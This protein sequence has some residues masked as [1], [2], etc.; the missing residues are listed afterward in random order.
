MLAQQFHNLD[1]LKVGSHVQCGVA[2]CVLDFGVGHGTEQL[3]YFCLVAVARRYVQQG[4]SLFVLRVE[5]FL[6]CD[7][8]VNLLREQ[9]VRAVP[10]LLPL[11]VVIIPCF[12]ERRVEHG[13][14]L[15]AI[16]KIQWQFHVPVDG[17]WVCPHGQQLFAQP[18]VATSCR[19]MQRC[20]T[21]VVPCVGVCAVF[22]QQRGHGNVVFNAALMQCSEPFLIA[23]VHIDAVSNQLFS[24]LSV[25][26]H[27]VEKLVLWHKVD[28]DWDTV[29]CENI[30]V[31]CKLKLLALV[32]GKHHVLLPGKQSFQNFQLL[33]TPFSRSLHGDGCALTG[34]RGLGIRHSLGKQQGPQRRHT[35]KV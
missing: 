35:A 20:P 14:H 11:V 29:V 16:G 17:A 2:F 7:A 33:P 19:G 28:L 21:I 31:M 25:C 13:F 26:L 4:G 15:V 3:F 22:Q 30:W 32:V 1:L 27:G 8:P 12:R 10:Q 5:V 23:F 24:E 9:Y 18:P 6:G 34:R